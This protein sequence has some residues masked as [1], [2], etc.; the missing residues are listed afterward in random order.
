MCRC[1]PIKSHAKRCHP[2]VC[3]GMFKDWWFMFG[4]VSIDMTS[5]LRRVKMRLNA[6]EPR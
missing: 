2:L 5:K 3:A 6:V 4:W 1:L